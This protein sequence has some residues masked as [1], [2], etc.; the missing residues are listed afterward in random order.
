MIATITIVTEWG[1]TSLTQH[2]WPIESVPR[3]CTLEMVDAI[4]EHPPSFQ[5]KWEAHL[6][7]LAWWS[8]SYSLPKESKCLIW[9]KS[10]QEVQKPGEETCFSPFCHSWGHMWCSE[11]PEGKIWADYNLMKLPNQF[12]FPIQHNDWW[13]PWALSQDDFNW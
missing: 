10:L 11:K 6:R 5:N 9:V 3:S 4:P 13:V 7:R 8:M 12:Y 2:H 1:P